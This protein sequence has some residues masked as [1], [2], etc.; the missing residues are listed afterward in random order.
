MAPASEDRLIYLDDYIDLETIDLVEAGE[1]LQIVP[2]SAP[3][4]TIYRRLR[5]KNRH[6]TIYTRDQVP[7][8][9]HYR[10]NARI[11]P[12]LGL[13]DEGWIVTS[14]EAEASRKPDA[15]PRRG[16]HGYDPALRSMHALF[17]AAGP[18]IRSGLLVRPFENIHIYDLLC[19][20]LKLTPGPNDGDPAVT[21][22]FLR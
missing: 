18:P 9:F 21:R 1:F 10:D 2:R 15:K 7:A 11:P 3:A 13:V 8:R 4:E 19:A 22:G 20:V 14:W 5:G 16:A 12:I 17:V 6:L